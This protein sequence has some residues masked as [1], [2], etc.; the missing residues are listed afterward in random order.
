MLN[1]FCCSKDQSG[2]LRCPKGAKFAVT[3]ETNSCITLD[4]IPNDEEFNVDETE[5]DDEIE[6]D[7]DST[8]LIETPRVSNEVQKRTVG[9]SRVRNLLG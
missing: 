3:S 2:T 6:D 7:P 9:T 1:S 8:M 4:N 5:D